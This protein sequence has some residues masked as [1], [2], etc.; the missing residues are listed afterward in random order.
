MV[1]L[2]CFALLG[3]QVL[4]LCNR[5][6]CGPCPEAES[7]AVGWNTCDTIGSLTMYVL[8]RSQVTV[9]G[10]RLGATKVL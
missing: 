2:A 6:G 10:A 4:Q 8:A 9:A 1:A 7:A 5:R 3:T